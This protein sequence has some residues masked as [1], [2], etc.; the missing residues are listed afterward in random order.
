MVGAGPENLDAEVSS[1]SDSLLHIL[2]WKTIYIY[3]KL[4]LKSQRAVEFRAAIIKI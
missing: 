3:K 4:C 2:E 1:L